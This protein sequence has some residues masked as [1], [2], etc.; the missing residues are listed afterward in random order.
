MTDFSDPLD[1]LIGPYGAYEKALVITLESFGLDVSVWTTARGR[2]A[3]MVDD[4]ERDEV[5]RLDADTPKDA[6]HQVWLVV[7]AERAVKTEV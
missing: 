7:R 6:L 5:H 1:Q 4:R 2:V 3:V